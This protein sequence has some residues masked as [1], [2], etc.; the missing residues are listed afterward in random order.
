MVCGAAHDQWSGHVWVPAQAPELACSAIVTSRKPGKQSERRAAL[1]GYVG[2]TSSRREKKCCWKRQS[3]TGP[4][5]REMTCPQEWWQCRVRWRCHRETL[6]RVARLTYRRC[7]VRWPSRNQC[8]TAR[9]WQAEQGWGDQTFLHP[10]ECCRIGNITSPAKGWIE[11]AMSV[12][13]RQPGGVS[14]RC[15]AS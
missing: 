10:R 11:I 14:S 7:P 3:F 5:L 9:G 13:V 8:T 2:T 4:N 15:S 6:L 1:T 12:A